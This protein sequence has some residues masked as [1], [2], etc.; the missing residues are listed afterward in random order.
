MAIVFFSYSHKDQ[1]P[2]DELEAHLASLKHESLID[3]WH[4]RRIEAGSE[5]DDVIF[6][7]MES[8]DIILLLVSSDFLASP[9]CYS[10]EMV[11]A[12]ERH[13]AKTGVVIPVILRSCD[14]TRAP[15]GKLLAAPR[16][17]KPVNSW[18]D[19]DEAFTDV[20]KRVRAVVESRSQ[21]AASGQTA[22][23]TNTVEAPKA[24]ASQTT[25]VVPRSSNLRLKKEFSEQDRDDFVHASFEYIVKFFQGSIDALV[26]RNLGVTGRL[27][28][29][30]SRRMTAVLYQHGK[31]V[32]E[33]SVQLGGLGGRSSD[34]ISFSH[35][36]SAQ[37]GS[38]NE[39]LN[40]EATAQSLHFKPMGFGWGGHT[41]DRQLSQEG[42][43]EHLWEMLIRRL[44]Q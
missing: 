11:R 39:L 18:P 8:A 38:F 33:C 2:R 19:R 22:R 34:G 7:T 35:S 31:G 40:V 15:F 4:D 6:N 26:E 14:W 25:E 13:N 20:A 43:A 42:A 24:L 16:D 17:G 27:D 9:Y 10:R 1:A 32:A 5:F 30:D 21:A 36:A 41:Q 12:M 29:I 44:Q 23:Q 37:P 28:R 3:T